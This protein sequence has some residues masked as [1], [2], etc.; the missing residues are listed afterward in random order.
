MGEQMTTVWKFPL[1]VVDRQTIEMPAD[2]RILSVQTQ[3]G[4]PCLWAAVD[5]GRETVLRTILV[6]GTGHPHGELPESFIGT[7]QLYAGDLVFHVFEDRS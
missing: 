5:P 7:F 4:T 2:A 1:E 6:V 3:H